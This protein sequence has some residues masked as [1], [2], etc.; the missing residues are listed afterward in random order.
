MTKFREVP[1]SLT[2]NIKLMRKVFALVLLASVFAASSCTK[3][4]IC[5]FGNGDKQE[6]CRKDY[7]GDKDMLEQAIKEYEAAGYTCE[8]QK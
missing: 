7:E 4:Y 2:H 1:L 8:A 6:F 5:D 3:C